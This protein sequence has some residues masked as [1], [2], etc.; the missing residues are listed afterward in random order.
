MPQELLTQPQV[1]LLQPIESANLEDDVPIGLKD[2]NKE[3][4]AY[5]EEL[6]L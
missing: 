3:W 4:Y 6:G 5:Q 1:G 2:P